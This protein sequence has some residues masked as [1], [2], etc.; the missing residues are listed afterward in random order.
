MNWEDHTKS[1]EETLRD[2]VISK[3]SEINVLKR[4]VN[5]LQT[6]LQQSYKRIEQLNRQISKLKG[7]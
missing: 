4:N 3:D 1:M 6:H 5:E 2:T 7:E